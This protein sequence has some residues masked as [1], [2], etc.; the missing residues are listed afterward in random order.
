MPVNILAKFFGGLGDT[1]L[2]LPVLAALKARGRLTAI[3]APPFRKLI[4]QAGLAD[5]V[6][7]DGGE[8][9]YAT[10]GK[11]DFASKVPISEQH[12]AIAALT[13]E[14]PVPRLAIPDSGEAT[15]FVAVHVCCQAQKSWPLLETASL[16]RRIAAKRKLLVISGPQDLGLGRAVARAAAIPGH[17]FKLMDSRPL[18]ELAGAL[19]GCSAFFGF[20]A[21]P[22]H[23]A[24]ALGIPCVATWRTDTVHWRPNGGNVTFLEHEPCEVRSIT[25]MA[26]FEALEAVWRP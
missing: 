9:D 24:A 18:E 10:E 16:C 3:V 25:V 14:N 21:G 8:F 20:E 4:L 15:G 7:D 5:T 2:F 23:L 1:I 19:A 26:A 13:G 22:T 17:S 6:L 11:V 12:L